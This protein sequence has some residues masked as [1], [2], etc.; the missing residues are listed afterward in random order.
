MALF[1][2]SDINT[3]F[4]RTHKMVYGYPK[5]GKT[6]L[7]SLMHAGAK[8]PLFVMSEDGAGS[9][10]LH[11]ARVTNWEG[12]LKCI[13]YLESMADRIK[14]EHSCIV[15]DHLTDLESWASTY[16]AQKKKIEY[17]GDLDQGKGWKL[18]RQEIAAAIDRLFA[19]APITFIAHAQEKR[20]KWE[21]EEIVTTAPAL[22]KAAMEYVNGK[23]DCIMFIVPANSKKEFPSLTMRQSAAWIAGARQ[24]ALCKDYSFKPAEIPQTWSQ[25]CADYKA[26]QEAMIPKTAPAAVAQ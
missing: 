3:D 18:L 6:T 7:A 22:G 4:N 13:A 14:A 21:G 19:L 23:V 26:A 10:R 1:P 16:V 17:V 8:P 5:A 11:Q 20:V 24:Q 25:I 15:I 2:Q 12:F 9:L